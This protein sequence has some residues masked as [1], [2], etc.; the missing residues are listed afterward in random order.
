MANSGN[1]LGMAQRGVGIGGFLGRED[2]GNGAVANEKE[3]QSATEWST[4]ELGRAARHGLT[5][6][7][8]SASVLCKESLPHS[9]FFVGGMKT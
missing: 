9:W 8:S 3:Y 7:T 2:G 4:W 1:I 6:K 5:I